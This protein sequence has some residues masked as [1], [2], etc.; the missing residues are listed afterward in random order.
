MSVINH[1]KK[2]PMFEHFTSTELE[3]V[4]KISRK[5]GYRKGH[6]IFKEG[7]DG[8]SIYLILVGAVK[9]YSE[10]NGKEKIIS[11]F[12]VGENFGELALID[13]QPR[14]ASAKA[15][16][17]SVL[18]SIEREPFMEV[19]SKNFQTAQKIMEELS[20]RIRI[21]NQHVNDLVFHDAKTNV[22]KTLINL[23]LKHGNR[24]KDLIEVPTKLNIVDIG[25]LAGTSTEVVNLVLKDLESKGVI[26]YQHQSFYL[27][28]NN[29]N[30]YQQQQ[31]AEL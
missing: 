12:Q 10:K 1:L 7:D 18:V 22:V 16:E 25:R 28:I 17:D 31:H 26:K 29:A 8:D 14:S 20:N 2:V 27:Y 3:K 21:T 5:H 4:E 13:T 19:L 6:I 30:K 23:A 9:I 24:F 11:T 15:I